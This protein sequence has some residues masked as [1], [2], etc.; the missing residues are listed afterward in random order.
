MRFRQS[1]WPANL[2]AERHPAGLSG[3]ARHALLLGIG[4]CAS[5]AVQAEERLALVS[6]DGWGFER[7]ESLRKNPAVQWWAELGP[8]MLIAFDSDSAPAFAWDALDGLQA[9][10]LAVHTL[11]CQGEDRSMERLPQVFAGGRVALVRMP[12]SFAPWPQ[13]G[14]ELLEPLR[15]N[16]VYQR[17]WTNDPRRGTAIADPLVQPLVDFVDGDRWFADVETLAAWNRSSCGTEVDLARDWI[18]AQFQSLGMDIETDSFTVP[19]GCGGPRQAQNIRALLPGSKNPDEWIVIGAHYDSRQPA[20]SNPA[21]TPGAEDNASG[22]AGVIEMARLLSRFRPGRSV[23][24]TCYSGEEQGLFGSAAQVNLLNQSGDLARV[25][26]MLNMDMIGYSAGPPLA[27]TVE[28]RPF[29]AELL[30]AF[31]AAAEAY[32][33][34]LSLLLRQ[35]ACCSDHV[36]Y[37]NAGVPAVLTIESDYAIYPHY[38]RTTDLPVHLSIPMGTAIL[39]MNAAVLAAWT[40]ASDLLFAG[41]FESETDSGFAVPAGD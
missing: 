26:R 40:D 22:C 25:Q 21:N 5:L 24:F 15:R 18:G 41:A 32:V 17:L 11:G 10:D 37:L 13:R 36:P 27:V 9:R 20:I 29:A 2:P 39:R 34:D 8:A 19:S 30:P 38:H 6:I 16:T 3:L 12:R 7:V 1:W 31:G 14:S 33:P 4:L 35:S 23:L 28:T